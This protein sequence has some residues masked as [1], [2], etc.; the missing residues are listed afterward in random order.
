MLSIASTGAHCAWPRQGYTAAD[1]PAEFHLAVVAYFE[2]H[3]LRQFMAEARTARE[4]EGMRER[5]QEAASV[6]YIFWLENR[7]DRI[8]RGAHGSALC[9]VRRFMEKSRWLGR[10][11]GRRASRRAITGERIDRRE[12]L[13]QRNAATPESVAIAMERIAKTPMHAGKAYR[14]AKS[15]GLQGIREL[16]KVACGFSA[17]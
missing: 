11:E 16:V 12:R 3:A 8:P 13:R 4:R 10:T 9:G 17:E 6:A 2:R 15:L 1:L 5:A 7:T 14:L